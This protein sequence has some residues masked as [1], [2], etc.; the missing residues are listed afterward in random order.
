M[1]TPMKTDFNGLVKQLDGYNTLDKNAGGITLSDIDQ[2]AESVYAECEK[3]GAGIPDLV[4]ICSPGVF[5]KL[6]SEKIG[7]PQH[8]TGWG[9]PAII[10]Y[11]RRGPVPVIMEM[12][13]SNT[14]GTMAM[15]FLDMRVVE[16]KVEEDLTC[17]RYGNN[18]FKLKIK[19]HLV[20]KNPERCASIVG[21]GKAQITKGEM[22]ATMD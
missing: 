15:Y 20:V 3:N 2:A 6:I 1:M 21:I 8:V 7:H 12:F 5:A 17:E 22:N 4:A 13:L 16:M 10:L 19:E 11:T 18:Q 9:F 14:A